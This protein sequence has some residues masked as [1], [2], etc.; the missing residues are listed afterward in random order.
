MRQHGSYWLQSELKGLMQ[1]SP[2]RN[3]AS[4]STFLFLYKMNQVCNWDSLLAWCGDRVWCLTSAV[5]L[6]TAPIVCLKVMRLMQEQVLLGEKELLKREMLSYMF[7]NNL[8]FTFHCLGLPLHTMFRSNMFC[9]QVK[10]VSCYF[11]K[12]HNKIQLKKSY[13]FE[14]T[15]TRGC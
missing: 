8:V 5:T 14:L 10:W 4:T 3:N 11:T 1:R 12:Y 9:C 15:V 7:K 6:A 2:V 13:F